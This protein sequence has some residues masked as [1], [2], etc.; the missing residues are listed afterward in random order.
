MS[1]HIDA[2]ILEK[3]WI[4]IEFA[5]N[6][7]KIIFIRDD[8]GIVDLARWSNNEWNA[9]FGVCGKPTYFAELSIA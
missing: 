9:E 2:S 4:E 1:S 6:D 7:G 8:Y 3:L 5:P